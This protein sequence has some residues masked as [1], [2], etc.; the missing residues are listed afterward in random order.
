MKKKNK[1]KFLIFLLRN[2]IRVDSIFVSN[3]ISKELVAISRYTGGVATFPQS[4]HEGLDFF[5]K[6]DFFYVNTRQFGPMRSTNV[7]TTELLRLP[8]IR[9]NDLDKEIKTKANEF[10]DKN[11]TVTSP[12]L[13]IFEYEKAIKNKILINLP[14]I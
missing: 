1:H 11:K 13:A 7:T 2:T 14:K 6:E 8:S 3:E 10:A 9:V 5:R 4:Y 12:L